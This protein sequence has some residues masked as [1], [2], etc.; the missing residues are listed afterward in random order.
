MHGGFPVSRGRG[1][2]SL[3]SGSTPGGIIEG[4]LISKLDRVDG[5]KAR[6]EGRR[7]NLKKRPHSTVP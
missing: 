5:Q 7:R 1:L 6:I 2:R 4:L 3:K